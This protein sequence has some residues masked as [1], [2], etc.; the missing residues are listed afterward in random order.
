[1][2][3]ILF[4]QISQFKTIGDVL[5]IKQ[6][7]T[8]HINDSYLIEAKSGKYMV[9]R[10]NHSVF[11]NVPQLMEN[12]LLISN[13][14]KNKRTTN[15]TGFV[16][17]ELVNTNSGNCFYTDENGDFWRMYGFIEGKTYD[18]V[19]D[20]L[21]A[22][23]GAGAVGLF[24]ALLSDLDVAKLHYTIQRFH[25]MDFRMDN[26]NAAL[27]KDKSKRSMKCHNE[28]NKLFNFA[29]EVS[30]LHDQGKKGLFPLR[31]THN[32]TKFNNILFDKNQKAIGLIDLDTVMPGYL[33]YDFGDA[34]RTAANTAVED[35][36]DLSAINM[37]MEIYSAYV[38][39]YLKNAQSFITPAEKDFLALS[40]KYMTF[41]MAL[42]FLT[43][44]L[45]SDI[46]YKISHEHHNLQRARAQIKLIE[47]MNVH[48]IQMQDIIANGS[49]GE[50]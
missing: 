29:K 24:H 43:D 11:K 10:I 48:F 47:S 50:L 38:Q 36:T 45:D 12:M 15:N 35:E 4:H 27:D 39:G 1:M 46:Y 30:L 3:D 8:G 33:L 2:T 6:L 17:P 26:F 23:E 31:V 18:V 25:D 7:T 41:I 40:A 34:I 32:D 14:I 13:H 19:T 49:V 5:A 28:I 22:W 20:P 44:Y 21:I 42:R 16:V 37:N 9:Q